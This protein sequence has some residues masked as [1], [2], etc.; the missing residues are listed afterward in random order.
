MSAFTHPR[1]LTIAHAVANFSCGEVTLDHWLK[2]HALRNEGHGA[3]RTYVVCVEQRVVAYSALATGAIVSELA[4][5]GLRRNMPNPIPVMVLGR[6]AVDSGWRN[7]GLGKALLRDAILRSVQVSELV[8]VKALLVHALSEEVV[9]FY[10]RHGFQSS[11]MHPK[12]LF[13]KL[14]EV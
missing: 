6:L 8:G 5:R 7:H 2:H 11:P 9:Q 13:L 10:D 12:T 4:P 14:S 3:S 1:P